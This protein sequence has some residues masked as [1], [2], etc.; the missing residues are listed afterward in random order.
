MSQI[1]SP[2]AR[3]LQERD[4]RINKRGQNQ[5]EHLTSDL[6]ADYEH[7]H[8]KWSV[9]ARNGYRL[10]FATWRRVVHQPNALVRELRTTLAA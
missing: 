10:V 4:K 9:P 5:Y 6:A 8:E 3:Y 2:R 1:S 7:D